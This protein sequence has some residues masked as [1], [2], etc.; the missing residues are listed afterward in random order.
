M[1]E[2]EA[3]RTQLLGRKGGRLS[4]IMAGLAKMP[5]GERAEFGKRANEAKSAVEAELAAAHARLEGAA[6]EGELSKRYDVTLSAVPPALGS[7][8][9][10]RRTLDD[11][12]AFF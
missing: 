12:A 5:A 1:E 8:H 7:L 10:L 6:L 9:V 2:I 3:L 4:Q 11:I